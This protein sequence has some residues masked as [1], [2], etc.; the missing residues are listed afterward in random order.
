MEFVWNI[1]CAV[2][3][4]GSLNFDQYIYG[5]TPWSGDEKD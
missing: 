4:D 2:L 1:Y 5:T 3:K